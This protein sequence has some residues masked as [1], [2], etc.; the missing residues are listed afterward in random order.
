MIYQNRSE[1]IPQNKRAEYNEAILAA[2]DR[3]DTS[4]CPKTVYNQYTGIGGLHGLRQ[5]D[6]DSYQRYAEA[7]REFEM[8]Q[9]VLYQ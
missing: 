6:F 8:G 7:K 4:L 5:D 9:F 3:D 1:K 2:I